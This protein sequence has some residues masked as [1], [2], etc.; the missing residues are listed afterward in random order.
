MKQNTNRWPRLTGTIV[1]ISGITFGNPIFAIDSMSTGN[2]GIEGG[3][4]YSSGNAAGDSVGDG[5]TPDTSASSMGDSNRG[6]ESNPNAIVAPSSSAAVSGAPF[7][8]VDADR[9]SKISQNEFNEFRR[10][11][12]N[13]GLAG[14][15]SA[16][17]PSFSDMDSNRDGALSSSE[18][19]S[20]FR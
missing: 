19:R 9:N 5:T 20:V 15:T 3:V 4:G 17:W 7:D 14:K 16:D 18:S 8:S 2:R 10:H 11:Y 6:N 13:S 1:L 12:D